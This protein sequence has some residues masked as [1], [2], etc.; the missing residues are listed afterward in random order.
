MPKEI[1]PQR[2]LIPT[3]CIYGYFAHEVGGYEKL[4]YSKRDMYNNQFKQRGSKSFDADD[5]IDF[6]KGMCYMDDVIFWRHIVNTDGHFNIC[7]G[8]TGLVIWTTRYLVMCCLLM[9]LIEK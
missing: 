7:F 6:L 5:A 4:C 1:N 9:R 2:K 3:L 8:V